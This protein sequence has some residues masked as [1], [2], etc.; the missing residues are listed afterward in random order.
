MNNR[1]I[2]LDH[3]FISLMHLLAELAVRKHAARFRLTEQ[4]F[5][6]P[7]QPTHLLLPRTYVIY[8]HTSSCAKRGAM[9]LRQQA[10]EQY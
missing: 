1:C 10:A 2:Q 8:G 7:M 3:D 5:L 6:P 9:S 4:D